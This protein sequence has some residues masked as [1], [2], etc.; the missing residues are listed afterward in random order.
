[1]YQGGGGRYRGRG[2][3]SSYRGGRGGQG[4]AP[5]AILKGLF[6]DGIWQCDC[7]PRLPAEHFKVK[8]EGKNQGRWFYTCQNQEPKRCGF[9]LWDE[10]AKPREE[11]A[12]LGGS[13]TEPLGGKSG[14]G[15]V[16]EGWDA[17]RAQRA[18][19]T[20]GMGANGRGTGGMGMF[21]RVNANNGD[22]MREDDEE[23]ASPTPSP[24][25][26]PPPYSSLRK[27]PAASNG[28]KRSAQQAG[29]NEEDDE[30]FFPWPLTGQEEQELAK[31]A[32]NAVA[33]PETPHKA[34]K[35]GV[36]ATPATTAKRKLPWLEQSQAPQTPAT[37]A[38][39]LKPVDD[40]FNTPSKPPGGVTPTLEQRSKAPATAAP[41]TTPSPPTRYKDALQNPADSASSLTT[42]AIAAL[43]PATIPPDIRDKLRS[44]LSKHD[45]KFQGITKGR[46]IS[47][48]AI[49]A[50]DAKIAELGARIAG[51]ENARIAE[52]QARVRSLD[53]EREVDRAVIGAL[54]A[55]VRD[56][57]GAAAD[58]DSQE[59][60]G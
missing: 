17:G 53:A 32:D 9:F 8:K 40:C 14:G 52:L 21:A 2:G 20:D 33:P 58:I 27:A 18:A 1:M 49:K 55:Q 16:Q 38:A 37:T 12:V 47:R 59:T 34:Q 15:E 6:A 30:E 31:A 51:L 29:M 54:R 19:R 11:A 36:Y 35:T 42:E 45:L 10:D 24:V 46:D 43:Q 28:V 56:G 13:R 5:R 57:G 60:I 26:P 39:T 22:R 23:T 7:A 50:K 41:I 3:S 4:N 48:L 44:I 25:S